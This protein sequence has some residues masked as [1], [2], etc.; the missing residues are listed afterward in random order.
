[1]CNKSHIYF[2]PDFSW[3]LKKYNLRLNKVDLWLNSEHE[4]EK[5]N[6]TAWLIFLQKHNKSWLLHLEKGGGGILK[7][8]QSQTKAWFVV[9]FLEIKS[10]QQTLGKKKTCRFINSIKLQFKDN[11]LREYWLVVGGGF[12]LHCASL[13]HTTESQSESLSLWRKKH[14]VV[15]LPQFLKQCLTIIFS[16][17]NSACLLTIIILSPG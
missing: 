4:K 12:I 1:M 10:L 9:Y 11:S 13:S 2:I 3:F 5:K 17:S 14:S 7:T 8:Y 15:L 16:Y 6:L